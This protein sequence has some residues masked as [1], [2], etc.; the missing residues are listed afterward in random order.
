[1]LLDYGSEIDAI[2]N[3]GKTS[4]FYACQEG[5]LDMVELLLISELTTGGAGDAVID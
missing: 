3:D 5:Y 4:L 1:M 2:D